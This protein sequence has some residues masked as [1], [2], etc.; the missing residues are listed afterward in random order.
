MFTWFL[1][2]IGPVVREENAT[3]PICGTVNLE[4]EPSRVPSGLI[5]TKR[6]GFSPF[7][8]SSEASSPGGSWAP[9]TSSHALRR[10]SMQPVIIVVYAGGKLFVG[11]GVER[12][13]ADTT[14]EEGGKGMGRGAMGGKSSGGW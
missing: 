13:R 3:Q 5:K 8:N 1:L 12:R 11:Y 14:L 7:V 10:N 9:S 2:V 4:F 6:R